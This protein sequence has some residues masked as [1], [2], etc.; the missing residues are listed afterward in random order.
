MSLLE[1]ARQK[2]AEKEAEEKQKQLELAKG[3]ARRQKEAVEYLRTQVEKLGDLPLGYKLILLGSEFCIDK[4]H[5][6]IAKGCVTHKPIFT[7]TDEYAIESGEYRMVEIYQVHGMV[8]TASSIEGF[9]ELLA[10][11]IYNEQ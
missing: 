2:L 1:Q 10:E 11:R 3:V 6:E 7:Y 4:G 9:A 5:L 8:K